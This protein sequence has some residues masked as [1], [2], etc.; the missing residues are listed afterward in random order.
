MDR[1]QYLRGVGAGA[2][3]A[4]AGCEDLLGYEPGDGDGSDDTPTADDVTP[5]ATSTPPTGTIP[6]EQTSTRSTTPTSTPS[7][8]ASPLPGRTPTPTATPPTTAA[9]TPTPTATPDR[10]PRVVDGTLVE[11]W[12][13]AADFDAN[14]MGA[15][16]RGGTA[17]VAFAFDVWAGD[18]QARIEADVTVTHR[19]EEVAGK[20][21]TDAR[22]VEQADEFAR[23]TWAVPFDTTGWTRGEHTAT[24]RLRDRNLDADANPYRF[25]F[26]LRLPLEGAQ[27][28]FVRY[29]GPDPVT[30]G[31]PFAFEVSVRNADARDGTV[32]SPIEERRNV[33]EWRVLDESVTLNVAA[34]NVRAFGD[35]WQV[36]RPGTYE[37]RLSEVDVRWNLE[38]AEPD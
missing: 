1:R 6:G 34:G 35:E 24:I 27:A 36:D 19:D 8:T 11:S 3:V 38:V 37:W 32:V 17:F 18:G 16:G 25:D 7:A 26:D 4:L 5:T 12:P 2:M 10:E 29:E 21:A 15:V 33:R 28:E 14:G 23:L 30:A 9:P 22:I 20:S 13:E 31:E